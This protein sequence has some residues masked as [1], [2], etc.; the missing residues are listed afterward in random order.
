MNSWIRFAIVFFSLFVGVGLLP[1]VYNHE[2]YDH[3][4]F[5]KEV[6]LNNSEKFESD[7]YPYLNNSIDLYTEQNLIE[8][9]SF[10]EKKIQRDAIQF[11]LYRSKLSEIDEI[12]FY[13]ENKTPI[14]TEYVKV[15]GKSF[16]KFPKKAK[17]FFYYMGFARRNEVY[18]L[19]ESPDT[20]G[21]H[22]Y[23]DKIVPKF[24]SVNLQNQISGG[25]SLYENEQ[26]QFIKERYI[27]QIVRLYYFNKENK[28][29]IQFYKKHFS[30]IK[31][32]DSMKWRSLGYVAASYADEGKREQANY[33]YS[34][35]YSHSP[36][37][38]KSAYLSFQPIEEKDFQNS[39]QLTRN[40][41][42]KIMLWYLFGKRFD[43]PMAMSQIHNLDPDSKYLKL[44]LTFLIKSKSSPVFEGGIDFWKY[45]DPQFHKIIPLNDKALITTVNSIAN[46]DRVKNK[47]GWKIAAAYLNYLSLNFKDGDQFLESALKLKGNVEIFEKQYQIT[48]LLG[49]LLRMETIDEKSENTILSE[50]K[51]LFSKEERI[52]KDLNLEF[53]R[54]WVRGL[55]GVFYARKGELEKAEWIRSGIIKNRFSNL[56]NTKR[57]VD[58]IEGNNHSPL[59]QV[60]LQSPMHS[61]DNYLMLLGI[62]YA[63]VEDLENS[64][65]AF[66][67]IAESY[68]GY[69]E[70]DYFLDRYFYKNP[71][72]IE[73][74][75]QY[76]FDVWSNQ[77]GKRK[78]NHKTFLQEMIRLK[79]EADTNPSKSSKT[80]FKLANAF[81][82][83]N[84]FGTS[85]FHFNPI[86]RYHQ[87]RHYSGWSSLCYDQEKNKKIYPELSNS[88]ALKYYL[89]ARENSK[90]KEFKAK[91]TFMAA[92]CEQNDW[93]LTT[94]FKSSLCSRYEEDQTKDFQ[95][96]KYFQELRDIYSDT[97]YHSEIIKECSYYA[98]Y[99]AKKSEL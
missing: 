35:L 80:Y 28:K 85:N 83:M 68:W 97:K 34:L 32:T 57:M 14:K 94:D 41:E 3:D 93:F 73:I 58:F 13:L 96:G 88:I 50:I 25:I 20:W 10:F 69:G 24:E 19:D 22:Q 46:Q 84:Y 36:I 45:E 74:T 82:N 40:N 5:I 49:K 60:M 29:S 76:G 38:K 71:F 17:A 91:M 64:L 56:E 67:K 59:I 4:F 2:N 61:Y 16:L 78:Y 7:R 70:T 87:V 75:D 48:S 21:G 44:L 43:V 65:K 63:Q 79:K 62:R 1:C 90:S 47:F 9:E 39:L 72:R 30:E 6:I 95:P 89:L 42:E 77:N 31:L 11:W 8:W 81:Y 37:Q 12:L 23:K 66:E 98:R 51:F 92:K 53:S 54:Y 86:Y 99:Y 18:T 26:F 27:F 52:S 15:N 55:L 33:I